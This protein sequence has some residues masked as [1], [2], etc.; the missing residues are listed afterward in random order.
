M[1]VITSERPCLQGRFFYACVDAGAS[2]D[3]PKN[4]IKIRPAIDRMALAW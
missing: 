2:E 3:A 1:S 4:Q